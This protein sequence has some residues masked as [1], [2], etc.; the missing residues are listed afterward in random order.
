MLTKKQKK[1]LGK[2][3]GAHNGFAFDIHIHRYTSPQLDG[4]LDEYEEITFT[5]GGDYMSVERAV[6]VLK[7][8]VAVLEDK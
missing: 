4:T 6:E 5:E 8:L 1:A 3:T 2:F 7:E